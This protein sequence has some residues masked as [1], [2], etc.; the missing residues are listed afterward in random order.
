MRATIEKEIALIMHEIVM[1]HQHIIVRQLIYSSK[2][3]ALFW[4]FSSCSLQSK[5]YLNKPNLLQQKLGKFA[6]NIVMSFQQKTTVK[7][8]N[9]H[10][11][12]MET[13][14]K[15]PLELDQVN[16]KEQ[17]VSLF[18]AADIP[19]YKLNHPSFKSLFATMEKYYLRKL[20]PGHG[21]VLL[22]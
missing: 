17:V 3:L 7:V 11:K 16:F 14:S 18:L 21:H 2:T 20:Q 13:K 1:M 10:K 6:R 9:T 5:E 22:N 15:S 8:S 4:F 19:L 12:K